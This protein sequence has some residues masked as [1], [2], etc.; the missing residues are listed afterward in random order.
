MRRRVLNMYR[1][2]P[3]GIRQAIP[4]ALIAWG[5]R[6]LFP[7]LRHKDLAF[8]DAR[9]LCRSKQVAKAARLYAQSTT[10]DRAQHID[11]P[12]FECRLE[13]VAESSSDASAGSYY[14]EFCY[15]GLKVIAL[16]SKP[17][18]TLEILVDDV[19]VRRQSISWHGGRA[20]VSFAI[21]RGVIET[22]PSEATITLRLS[23]GTLLSNRH[24]GFAMKMAVP[25]G[26][27]TLH[28]EL[29]ARGTLGKKGNFATTAEETREQQQKMLQ[30]YTR[31]TE[32]FEHFSGQPLILVCGTLLGQHRASDFIA[33]D[34]DFDVG[35]FSHH[36]DPLQVKN[37][38]IEHMR[39]FLRAGFDVSINR[40]GMP[41]RLSHHETGD[42]IF[43]DITPVFSTRR[44]GTFLR[45]LT[46]LDYPIQHWQPIE[47]GLMQRTSIWKP[48]NSDIFLEEYYGAGWRWPDPTFSYD[49]RGVAADV[50][51]TLQQTYL[52]LKEQKRLDL[53]FSRVDA[54]GQFTPLILRR[55]YP[56]PLHGEF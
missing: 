14:L 25:H 23:D 26:V 46:R 36:V 56:L 54:G 15:V 31:A 3:N 19:V 45:K 12:L 22:F 40:E 2:L 48:A 30:L 8:F 24:G 21:K 51:H 47:R 13:T 35:Y 4:E 50:N 39:T 44:G 41:F 11:D 7:I 49:D 20:Q 55:P 27:G 42:A 43:L 38:S 16:I 17:S 18:E 34:D 10:N 9:Y 53:E 6:R 52:S 5:A 32:A 33:G 1:G 28:D 37:E 29:R